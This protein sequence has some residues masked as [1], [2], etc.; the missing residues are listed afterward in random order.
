MNA[1]P[2]IPILRS[3]DETKAREFYLD[4]LGFDLVFEH[5]FD[6]NAPLY[7]GVQLGGCHLHISEHFDD[8]C[9]GAAVRIE[10]DDVRAFCRELNAKKYKNAR[11]EVMKQSWGFY[12][13]AIDDP[14]GNRIIFC[15]EVD[16]D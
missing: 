13:M 1:A 3:F 4:F 2:P 12:D 11:P 5:R 16:E 6:P 14:A 9:P 8:A 7:M 15:T 10:V